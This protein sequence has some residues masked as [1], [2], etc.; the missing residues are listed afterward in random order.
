MPIVED[1]RPGRQPKAY[2]WRV[3]DAVEASDLPPV[4]RHLMVTLCGRLSGRGMDTGQL[5]EHSPSLSELA[6]LTGWKA[7]PVKKYL[8]EL[9]QLGWLIRDQPPVK[10]QRAEKAKTK[11]TVR[12]P[13]EPPG[14]SALSRPPHDLEAEEARPPRDLESDPARSPDDLELGR[15][16]T[17]A[18]SPRDHRSDSQ[19]D[20]TLSAVAATIRAAAPGA[21]DDEIEALIAKIT[22]NC[23]TGNVAAYLAGFQASD[24]AAQ[25]AAVRTERKRAKQKAD[26]AEVARWRTWASKQPDCEHGQPGGNLIGPDGVTPCPSCR[27]SRRPT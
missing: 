22:P 15:H 17:R 25:I 14:M 10:L 23:R 21:T 19:T 20:Q 24:I 9:E 26:K 18:R 13:A 2:R 5:G 8:G 12:I 7:T 16:A 4:A 1:A 3:V 11:Y 6:R 27:Q